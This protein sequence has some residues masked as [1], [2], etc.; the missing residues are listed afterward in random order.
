[1][2]KQ[3]EG[4][5]AEARKSSPMS[6]SLGPAEKESLHNLEGQFDQLIQEMNEGKEDTGLLFYI[7]Q[8]LALLSD[9]QQIPQQ[10]K[11]KLQGALK[12]IQKE[13]HPKLSSANI[14]AAKQKV[15]EALKDKTL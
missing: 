3:R 2:E 11:Q 8:K 12:D 15:Q 5:W 13:S 10:V 1:M 4:L 6:G 7:G 14:E 9:N